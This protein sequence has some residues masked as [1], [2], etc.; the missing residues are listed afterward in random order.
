MKYDLDFTEY[1]DDELNNL[2]VDRL[3]DDQLKTFLHECIDQEPVESF[4]FNYGYED[5]YYDGYASCNL[6]NNPINHLTIKLN[7]DLYYEVKV[8]VTIDCEWETKYDDFNLWIVAV[9]YCNHKL[10]LQQKDTQIK[11]LPALVA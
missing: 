5:L 11:H 4:N 2:E 8:S 10:I 7:D 1:Y 6:L 3:N 9:T